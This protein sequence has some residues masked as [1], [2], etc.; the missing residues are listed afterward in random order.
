MDLYLNFDGVLW[1]GQAPPCEE[2]PGSALPLLIHAPRL[3]A[4]L[5]AHPN[6]DIV[7]AT[8]W[9][10]RIGQAATLSML[11]DSLRRR[12]V[13]DVLEKFDDEQWIAS[14]T[15]SFRVTLVEMA[16]RQRR[17]PR[18]LVLDN[19]LCCFPANLLRR[20]LMLHTTQGLGCPGAVEH[21][22]K[23]LSFLSNS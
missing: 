10:A 17:N 22:L 1:P 5:S 11:P 15:R 13:A 9:S 21:L 8:W 7:L 18:W 20:V 4:A 2:F 12:V 19:S 3:D 16:I 23:M 6:V 14:G